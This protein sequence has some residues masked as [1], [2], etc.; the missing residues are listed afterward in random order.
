MPVF[1]VAFLA[2]LRTGRFLAAFRTVRLILDFCPTG[3]LFHHLLPAGELALG[4]P[5]FALG[6]EPSIDG[7]NRPPRS[8]NDPKLG[9]Y[10]GVGDRVDDLT[11]RHW[12][13]PLDGSQI[14]APR[15][16]A[17]LLIEPARLRP[18]LAEIPQ[19]PARRLSWC[20]DYL[21]RAKAKTD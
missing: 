2:T 18:R 21:D 17:G 10:N 8:P 3:S 7:L 15:N 16:H 9:V 6:P 12:M 11:L 20:S 13:F 19:R 4:L 1:L 14:A 5:D